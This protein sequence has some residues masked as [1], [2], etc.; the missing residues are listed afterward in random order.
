MTTPA[1]FAISNQKLLPKFSRSS[2]LKLVWVDQS[3]LQWN[4]G[5]WCREYSSPFP[6]KQHLMTQATSSFR[7]VLAAFVYTNVSVHTINVHYSPFF[8]HALLKVA[9]EFK[10]ILQSNGCASAVVLVSVTTR[11]AA[12][13]FC[14]GEL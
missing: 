11:I 12:C 9:M 14:V 1:F 5:W 6:P 10:V 2:A 13:A 8:I 4:C 7:A 3:S